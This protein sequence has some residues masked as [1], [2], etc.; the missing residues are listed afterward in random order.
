MADFSEWI[1]LDA[2]LTTRLA[3]L[4]V[5]KSHLYL[6]LSEP[7]SG[8]LKIPIDTTAAGLITSG[9]FAQC[10]YNG[11]PRN[12]FF[13]ENI[14]QFQADAAEGGGRWLSIS[15]RGAL[16]L[17]DDAII[18]DDGSGSST[19]SFLA[20]TKADILKTLI[21]EAQARGVL[22]VLSLDF[23]ATDDSASVAWTDS[24]DYEL[25]VGMSLFDL[26]RQF[27]GT[28]IDFDIDLSGGSF[29]LSAYKNGLGTDKSESIYFRV[30]GNCEEVKSD[31][32]GDDIKNAYR[33]AWKDGYL[34]VSDSTSITN[35]RRREKLLDLKLAQSS[36]S[37]ST[38]S[39]AALEK[40]KLPH[41]SISVSIYDG[42]A[43]YLFDDYIIGD[44]IMLDVFG[45]ETK[46]RVLGI[47]ADFDG[48]SYA[49]VVVEL[50]NILYD[51]DL[52]MSNDLDWLKNQWATA[53]DAD[54]LEVRYWT[55]IGAAGDD[56]TS[57]NGFAWW[58]NKLV[59]VGSF[60]KMGG[61][62]CTGIAVYDTDT[63]LWSNELEGKTGVTTACVCVVGTDLY[64][65]GQ[66]LE[67]WD[68]G[69]GTWTK[70]IAQQSG[71]INSIASDGSMLYVCASN[72]IWGFPPFTGFS[73]YSGIWSYDLSTLA[74]T[75]LAYAAGTKLLMLG[76]DLYY[77]CRLTAP[78]LLIST[79]SKWDGS[80]WTQLGTD[81]DNN[82]FAIATNGTDI[83]V[84]G[85]FTG[86]ISIW[87]GSAWNV[88]D[89]SPG[90]AVTGLACYLSDIYAVGYFTTVGNYI[91]KYSGGAWQEL[92]GGLDG[93]ASNIILKEDDVYVGG[94]FENADDKPAY[95][96]AAY[97]TNFNALIDYL[98]KSST[99]NMGAA[100]HN[101]PASAITD[102][103]ELPFWE[104]TA[105]KLRK[106]TWANVKATAKT[107]FDTLYLSL[108]SMSAA[109]ALDLTDGGATTLHTHAGLVT[110]GDTHDHNGGD[111]GTIALTS[112]SAAWTTYAPT[113][114]ASN[115]GTFTHTVNG[116]RYITVGKLLFAKVDVTI[117]TVT[118]A[119]G[120]LKI[121]LPTTSSGVWTG[122]GI[123]SA[124]TGVMLFVA[125]V[126]SYIYAHKQDGNT[127][128]VANYRAIISIFGELA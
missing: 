57:I 60:A 91:A 3:I 116:A 71:T 128:L 73:A 30:G 118:T 99:F 28:G 53:H 54:L 62:D 70:L 8:E 107:Y 34:T 121:T 58:G 5:E 7:G 43:P 59:V 39:A 100:I 35:L 83:I 67:K 32:R 86:Y 44:Y 115:G 22:S 97:F 126:P 47:Q 42:L 125:A 127:L 103:D 13:V 1:L 120:E 56:I 74:W 117:N 102:S 95:K 10:N 123:E 61:V 85:S 72:S 80:S 29:V 81:F 75:D 69:T 9:M 6:E 51:N 12:G 92:Q 89:V 88:L 66:Y 50:N 82:V 94:V 105:K 46:Y 98:E 20:K 16:A 15:G 21:E 124:V 37:A 111:G 108:T 110:N 64:I 14:Q 40:T 101:A 31:E 96:I 90:A 68:A 23:T 25:N 84:G 119:A 63:G 55:G 2:D 48:V 36:A 41:K 49:N 76:S 38:Y 109:N 11:T 33:V 79:V 27:A 93:V 24:E 17:L 78:Y 45:V 106:I 114:T 112:L 26:V 104:D 113:V 77:V 18:W 52:K 122:S 4:P 65:G 87:D 19:R